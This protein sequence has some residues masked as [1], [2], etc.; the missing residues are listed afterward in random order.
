MLINCYA[1]YSFSKIIFLKRSGFLVPATWSADA[2][3]LSHLILCWTFFFWK[4]SNHFSPAWKMPFPSP[5]ESVLCNCLA[6][7]LATAMLTN[8]HFCASSSSHTP[9]GPCHHFQEAVTTTYTRNACTPL[10]NADLH[11]LYERNCWF[12]YTITV[13]D[14]HNSHSPVQFIQHLHLKIQTTFL[15]PLTLCSSSAHTS[16]FQ[17][18]IATCGQLLIKK[19][20]K[21]QSSKFCIA[22]YLGKLLR[23]ACMGKLPLTYYYKESPWISAETTP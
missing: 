15:F 10:N 16:H 9:Q 12:I 6:L 23:E 1:K 7:L 20:W 5:S 19:L 11:F 18:I 4:Y 2:D 13:S 17:D 14:H 8:G 3:Y 22:Q 21:V